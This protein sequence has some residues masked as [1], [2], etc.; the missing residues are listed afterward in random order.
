MWNKVSQLKYFINFQGKDTLKKL[1]SLTLK[2]WCATRWLGRSKCCKALCTAYGYILDHLRL[3]MSNPSNKADV[4]KTASDRYDALTQYDN[5]VFFFYYC[6]VT[7]VMARYSKLLQEHALQVSDVGR[8]ITR[9]C[10]RLESNFSVDHVFP[11]ELL[12]D[13]HADSLMR[14]LFP[15]H[16]TGGMAHCIRYSNY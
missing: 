3:E 12:A 14:E 6:D 15:E 1:P 2:G 7:A 8:L 9:L 4:K 5:F 10:K 11:T 13:G 16:G